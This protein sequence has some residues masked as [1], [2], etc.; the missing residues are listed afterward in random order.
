MKNIYRPLIIV[1]LSIMTFTI[2]AQ[3]EKDMLSQIIAEERETVDALV[4]YPQE[5]RMAILEACLHPELLV[6]INRV[7]QNSQSA[8]TT[9]VEKH[10]REVQEA[11]WDL[12]RYP[13]L[14]DRI[15]IAGPK[16]RD[17]L[18]VIAKDYPEEIR[19]SLVETGLNQFALLSEIRDLGNE[20]TMTFEGILFTWKYWPC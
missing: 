16:T 12:V 13:K 6:K 5:T 18:T 2:V 19:A 10:P 7:Q 15:V 17:E 1:L 4:L 8:F 9:L 3:E 20:A 11:V 14:I